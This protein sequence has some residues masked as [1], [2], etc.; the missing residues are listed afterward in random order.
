MIENEHSNHLGFNN[1]LVVYDKSTDKN[2]N[3]TEYFITSSSEKVVNVFHGVFDQRKLVAVKRILK[4][5]FYTT[6]QE[7]AHFLLKLSGLP[8]ILKYYCIEMNSDFWYIYY[9]PYTLIR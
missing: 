9:K 2:I 1:K 6:Y 7:E 8:N 3:E 4:G 5:S